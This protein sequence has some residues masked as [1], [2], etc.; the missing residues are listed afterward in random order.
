MSKDKKSKSTGIGEDL[1]VAI[2]RTE[3]FIEKYQKQLIYGVVAI[4]VVV[5]GVL[6][7]NRFYL[8]PQETEAQAQIAKGER[9]FAAD[10]FKL[11]IN[12]DG[13]DYIGFKRI[14]ENYGMTKSVNVANAYAGICSYKLGNYQQAIDYLEKFKGHGSINVSPVLIGLI[15]DSY[16]ELGKTDQALE[17]Y[18][19]AYDSDN[20]VFSPIFLKKAGLV[21]ESK[22]DF[23]KAIEFYTQIKDKYFQSA[24]AQDI[25]K[26]IE[27]AKLKK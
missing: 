18:K 24:E 27:R 11:A 3:A 4:V 26:Y 5:C 21:Y 13:V 1:E 17:Y 16:V 25:D 20:K 7:F 22:G 6:L 15:G 2:G 9:Y 12:G 19:K 8:A 14:I 10:S 23:A